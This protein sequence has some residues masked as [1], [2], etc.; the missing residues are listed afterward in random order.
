[1]VCRCWGSAWSAAWLAQG[2][3]AARGRARRGRR[4]A[5]LAAGQGLGRWARP[6]GVLL[7]GGCR[8][9]WRLSRLEAASRRERSEGGEERRERN[10]AARGKQGSDGGWL[11]GVEGARTLGLGP[12]A[13]RDV[14]P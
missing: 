9:C 6:G 2:R 13:L 8:G 11:A 14:G 12:G 5:L 10:A 4:R 7:R 3:G 1:M